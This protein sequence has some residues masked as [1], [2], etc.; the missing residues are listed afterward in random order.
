VIALVYRPEAAEE[1]EH[2]HDWYEGQREGLGG[3]FLAELRRAELKVQATPFAYRVLHRDTRRVL[4]HRFPY[5][6]LYRVV[7]ETVVVVACFHGRRSPK[8]W[9]RRR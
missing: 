7:E 1:V 8:R 5:Q 6:L 4:L 9:M 3:E 2:A